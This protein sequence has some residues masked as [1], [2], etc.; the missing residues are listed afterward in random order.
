MYGNIEFCNGDCSIELY[1]F[2]NNLTIMEIFRLNDPVL[3]Q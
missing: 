3:V 2:T 1:Y